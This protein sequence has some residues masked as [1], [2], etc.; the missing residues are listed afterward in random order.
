MEGSPTRH[1][2]R[3]AVNNGQEVLVDLGDQ[4]RGALGVQAP[5]RSSSH[6]RRR[7]AVAACASREQR[8]HPELRARDVRPSVAR[9]LIEDNDVAQ[10]L[11][12]REPSSP[13]TAISAVAMIFPMSPLKTGAAGIRGIWAVKEAGAS[14][15]RLKLRAACWTPDDPATVVTGT[16]KPLRC[17]LIEQEAP[18]R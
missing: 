3:F 4:A 17:S 2:S 14:W 15:I 7:R 1:P 11:L 18:L 9:L 12:S 8:D 13:M 10:P 6:G 16:T 5:W